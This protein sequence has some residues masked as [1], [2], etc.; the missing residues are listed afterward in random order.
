[1]ENLNAP[2]SSP[3]APGDDGDEDGGI[4]ERDDGEGSE[5]GEEEVGHQEVEVCHLAGGPDLRAGLCEG[6]FNFYREI[7]GL[8]DVQTSLRLCGREGHCRRHF[9]VIQGRASSVQGFT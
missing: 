7:F 6:E 8:T 3:A 4:G 5:V 2:G 1:M 9:C